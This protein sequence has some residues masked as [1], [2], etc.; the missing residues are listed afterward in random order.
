MN[1]TAWPILCKSYSWATLGIVS[2]SSL[3][4][5]AP[6][7]DAWVHGGPI[8]GDKMKKMDMDLA[9]Q[10]EAEVAD[11]IKQLHG[12]SDKHKKQAVRLERVLD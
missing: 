4:V 3:S 2:S 7:C 12:A 5:L 6:T 11:V 1:Q 9:E 10:E 8:K